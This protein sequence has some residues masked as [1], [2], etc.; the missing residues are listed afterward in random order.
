MD[1]TTKELRKYIEKHKVSKLENAKHD[2]I[3]VV[4]DIV[5]RVERKD[6]R[7]KIGEIEYT[8]SIYQRLKIDDPDEFDFDLP[9]NELEVNQVN[10]HL[11]QGKLNSLSF[12]L[13]IE[14]I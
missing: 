11:S 8:G 4:K 3:P 9:L 6:S 13:S 14:F 2:V 12:V 1:D 10:S 5:L 7:F